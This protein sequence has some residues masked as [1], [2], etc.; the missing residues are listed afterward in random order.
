MTYERKNWNQKEPYT[1]WTNVERNA[2]V[3]KHP[4]TIEFMDIVLKKIADEGLNT[5]LD[6]K[7]L[8]QTYKLI[9]K[10]YDII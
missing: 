8:K 9:C 7:F 10:K 3:E 4:G 1:Y 2:P 6:K 5:G